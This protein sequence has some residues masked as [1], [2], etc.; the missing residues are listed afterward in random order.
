MKKI[1]VIGGAG[2]VGSHQVKLL[3]N[4][5][6]EVVVLDNLNTGYEQAIDKRAKF[7]K[8]DIKD[9]KLLCKIF[10]EEQIE[11]VMH[12]AALSLVGVSVNEPL[13]YYDNNV[14]GM[15]VLLQAMVKQAIKYI[16]F[17]S[18]AATYGEHEQMPITEEYLTNPTNP[19]GE[20][21][22]AM[23]KMIKWTAKAHGLKYVSLR[24]FNVAGDDESGEIG[25]AHNPE[26]HLIPLVL[27]AAINDKPIKIFGN[28]YPTEDG[29]CIRDYIH[30]TDLVNAHILALEGLFS[31]NSSDIYNLGYGHGFSVHEIINTAEKVIGKII[32]KELHPRRAGDPAKLIAANDKIIKALGWKPQFDDIE[33]IISSAYKWHKNNPT[34]YKK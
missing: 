33:V 17:S 6:Y 19:Y 26:T 32:K 5:N 4:Q 24:Y 21:K 9:F 31:G 15:Q 11:A 30:V 23:E 14:Y 16:I 20:T 10:E 25:E 22:L 2:Y 3:C 7:I 29:T 18:T 34:G 27:Q 1:L 12:F 8:G 13:N 28:D